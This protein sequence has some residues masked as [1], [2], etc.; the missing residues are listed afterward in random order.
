MTN[1]AVAT[2]EVAVPVGG[3]AVALEHV[4]KRFGDITAVDGIDVEVR[5]GEFFSML[6]PSGSGK[7]TCLRM[8]AGF[9]QPTEGRILL[10]GA[11][12]AGGCR[13]ISVM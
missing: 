9:E 8:I 3:V 11:D 5:E 7:T 1:A 12:V 6:G 2:D 13:L 10:A 4:V